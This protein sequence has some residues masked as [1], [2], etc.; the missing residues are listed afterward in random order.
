MEL[1]KEN[2]FLRGYPERKKSRQQ[3]LENSSFA[4]L[5]LAELEGGE[6]DDAENDEEAEAAE[7]EEA[8][9]QKTEQEEE[10]DEE[11]QEEEAEVKIKKSLTNH[12]TKQTDLAGYFTKVKSQAADR[13]AETREQTLT[14]LSIRK[15][16]KTA[17]KS[18]EKVT[19][20]PTADARESARWMESA[21]R[22]DDALNKEGK[23][24][25]LVTGKSGRER[26]F[27][28]TECD[29]QKGGKKGGK[30][31]SAKKGDKPKSP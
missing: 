7:D 1:T 14:A 18:L 23:L 30:S 11:G 22:Q 13:E 26:K 15:T 16:R 6:D 12:K 25:T 29:Q 5:Q 3:K 8:I 31:K 24:L 9:E 28:M 2:Y 21:A 19:P 10:E 27:I 4:L 20:G 17:Q